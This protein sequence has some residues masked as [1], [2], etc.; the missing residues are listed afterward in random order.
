[1]SDNEATPG[2]YIPDAST[3]DALV[4]QFAEITGTDVACGQF[5]LQDR[6]WDLQVSNIFMNSA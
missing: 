4:S 2:N 3:A 1:M 6:N 5:Y